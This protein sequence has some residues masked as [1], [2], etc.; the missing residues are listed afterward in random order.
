MD[1]L[2]HNLE[3]APTK[4]FSIEILLQNIFYTTNTNLSPTATEFGYISEPLFGHD[5]LSKCESFTNEIVRRL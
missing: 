1:L 4:L 5:L 2:L 3:Q